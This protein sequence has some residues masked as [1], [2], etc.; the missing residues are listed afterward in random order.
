MQSNKYPF[1]GFSWIFDD[2][3][4]GLRSFVFPC[5]NIFLGVHHNSYLTSF[6]NQPS[7]RNEITLSNMVRRNYLGIENGEITSRFLF[8][9]ET[10]FQRRNPAISCHWC[11]KTDFLDKCVQRF[12]SVAFTFQSQSLWKEVAIL[13][14]KKHLFF[15]FRFKLEWYWARNFAL[16]QIQIQSWLFQRPFSATQIPNSQ[17]DS[18]WCAGSFCA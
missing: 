15:G 9:T 6:L 17:A 8:R 11:P 13:W 14:C 10:I 18:F 4:N 12:H 1:R 16:R 5:I 2:I 7:F 3:L